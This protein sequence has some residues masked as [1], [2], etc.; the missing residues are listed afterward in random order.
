MTGAQ[1]GSQPL[2]IGLSRWVSC[3]S[4]W[5]WVCAGDSLLAL[6]G[7]SWLSA[8]WGGVSLGSW[9]WFSSVVVLSQMSSIDTVYLGPPSLPLKSCIFRFPLQVMKTALFPEKDCKQSLLALLP[10]CRE[11]LCKIFFTSRAEILTEVLTDI[12]LVAFFGG[13]LTQTHYV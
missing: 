11:C 13:Q 12:L 8:W 1:T 4:P 5:R 9:L 10:T 3:H 2:K 7:T 6:A